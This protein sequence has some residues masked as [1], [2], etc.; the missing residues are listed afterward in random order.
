[1]YYLYTYIHI[2]SA[3]PVWTWKTSLTYTYI[4]TYIHAVDQVSIAGMDLEDI[5]QLAIGR[6]GS[7]VELIAQRGAYVFAVMLTRKSYPRS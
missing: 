6:E 2:K 7:E 4:H 3:S 1:M 5:A